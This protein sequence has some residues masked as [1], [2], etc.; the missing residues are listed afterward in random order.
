[1]AEQRGA[2]AAC[3]CMLVDGWALDH[4]APHSRGGS[5]DRSNLQGLCNPCHDAKTAKDR[6]HRTR[7]RIGIDGYPIE[8]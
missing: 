6:G 7:R 4:V 3:G 2:C 8:D 1:M 5:D